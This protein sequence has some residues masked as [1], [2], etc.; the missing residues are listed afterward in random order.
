MHPGK[1][2]KERIHA[3]EVSSKN[4]G[5]KSRLERVLRDQ[6]RLVVEV[7]HLLLKHCTP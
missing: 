3:K 6:R 5:L 4:A 1:L 2:A 7:S